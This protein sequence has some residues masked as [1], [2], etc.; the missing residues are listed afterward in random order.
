[1]ASYI[2]LSKIVT[3]TL[4]ILTLISLTQCV[5]DGE[6]SRSSYKNDDL[7]DFGGSEGRRSRRS[8]FSFQNNFMIEVLKQSP[9]PVFRPLNSEGKLE[10]IMDQYPRP[11]ILF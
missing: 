8:I 11:G 10:F 2:V 4:C 6:G 1:M 7:Q 5:L 3:V 9:A